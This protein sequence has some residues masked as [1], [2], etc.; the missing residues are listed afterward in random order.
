MGP[1]LKKIIK[2]KIKNLLQK[3]KQRRTK[4]CFIFIYFSFSS[5]VSLFDLRKSDRQN[6]SRE[7]ASAL[8]SESY[9]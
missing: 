6:S 1:T 9:A 3:K 8:L 7:E 2:K 5:L 4:V